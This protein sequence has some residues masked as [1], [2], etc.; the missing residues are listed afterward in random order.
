[1]KTL[2][3]L[4]ADALAA[5][6]A[7]ADNVPAVEIVSETVVPDVKVGKFGFSE[8]AGNTFQIRTTLSRKGRCDLPPGLVQIDNDIRVAS[9]NQ[10][11]GLGTPDNPSI[12]QVVPGSPAVAARGPAGAWHSIFQSNTAEAALVG[13]T[14]GLPIGPAHGVSVSNLVLDCGF[15]EQVKDAQGRFQTT[16]Q[17]ISIEGIGL[18]VEDVTTRNHA[19][20]KGGGECFPI[21]MFAPAVKCTEVRVA[22]LSR[23]RCSHVGSAGSTHQGAGGD[24]IT[25]FSLVGS[26]ANMLVAPVIEDCVVTGLKRGPSQP[27]PIHVFHLAYHVGGAIR[28]NTVLDSDATCV[29]TDTGR[30]RFARVH[31]NTFA[32]VHRGVFWNAMSDFEAREFDISDNTIRSYD[33]H[34]A[35][36][37][38]G[39]PAAILLQRV[40][41]IGTGFLRGVIAGNRISSPFGP[42][43]MQ[44]FYGRGIYLELRSKTDAV[45]LVARDNLIDVL[46]PGQG[47]FY[48]LNGAPARLGLYVAN[49]SAWDTAAPCLRAWGNRDSSGA[50]LPITVTD[51]GYIPRLSVPQN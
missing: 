47:A 12:I 14:F 43:G 25:L 48:T 19:K 11:R 49:Q 1:M 6:Q 31:G 26:P 30:S 18:V 44:S 35:W 2:T 37:V 23:V 8:A 4:V 39:T 17:A 22:R 40:G 42:M 3:E 21:R 36:N 33:G 29:Y 15:D 5:V 38:N 24:E 50:L 10:I 9:G 20:G 13:D 16:C 28:H 51:A 41:G 7:V 34:P 27:S 32:N 46:Q 45:G